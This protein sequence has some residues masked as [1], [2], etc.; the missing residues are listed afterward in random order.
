MSEQDDRISQEDARHEYAH[1]KANRNVREKTQ[2][3]HC[4]DRVPDDDYSW[5]FAAG[6]GLLAGPFCSRD[7]YWGWLEDE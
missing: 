6:G 2:C 7:C 1:A 3:E 4:G 5:K